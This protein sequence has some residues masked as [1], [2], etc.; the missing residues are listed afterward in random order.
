MVCCTFLL[1]CLNKALDLISSVHRQVGVA[2]LL[3][4]NLDFID[5]LKEQLLAHGGMDQILPF[6]IGQAGAGKTTA[7]KAAERFCFEFCSSCN[8]IW[9]DTSFVYTAYTGSAASTFGC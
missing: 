9:T 3:D 4:N 7:I 8:V 5:N 2:I 6:L 1:E